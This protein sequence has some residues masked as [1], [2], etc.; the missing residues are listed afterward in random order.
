VPTTGLFIYQRTWAHAVHSSS[1]TTHPTEFFVDDGLLSELPITDP[2]WMFAEGDLT[3]LQLFAG[4]RVPFSL[5]NHYGGA[6]N[7]YAAVVILYSEL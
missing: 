2:T 3:Q 1:G 6:T 4:L 7:C 5:S